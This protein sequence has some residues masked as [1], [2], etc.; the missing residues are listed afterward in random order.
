VKPG[1]YCLLVPGPRPIAATVEVAGPVTLVR[2]DA[3]EPALYQYYVS[4]LQT[5][6]ESSLEVALSSAPFA[7]VNPLIRRLRTSATISPV[8]LYVFYRGYYEALSLARWIES[9]PD[10]RIED[11]LA[12]LKT[13]DSYI[14]Q[15]VSEALRQQQLTQ[16][17]APAMGDPNAPPSASP[18]AAS[19]FDDG[20]RPGLPQY[21]SYYYV[22]LA[23]L[24]LTEAADKSIPL[25]SGEFF[26]PDEA[27]LYEEQCREMARRSLRW[28]QSAWPGNPLAPVLHGH[29]EFRVAP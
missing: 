2:S 10:G 16:D 18:W 23:T 8:E 1:P 5:L 28:A 25:S 6:D 24:F 3:W 13:N 4:L 12:R 22:G 20:S 17:T 26:H 11:F 14:D 27:R 21:R 15:L 7:Q 29:M 19:I 9:S